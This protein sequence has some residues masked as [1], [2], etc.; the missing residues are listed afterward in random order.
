MD[1]IINSENILGFQ[2]TNDNLKFVT[3]MDN[4]GFEA[5]NDLKYT[6]SDNILAF[7]LRS[8]H[9]LMPVYGV[10]LSFLFETG[11]IF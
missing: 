7:E 10:I 3:D 2:L 9:S 11:G 5:I 1:R 4:L 6:N 8:Y